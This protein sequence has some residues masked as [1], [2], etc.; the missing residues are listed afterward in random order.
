LRFRKWPPTEVRG[1][2]SPDEQDPVRDSVPEIWL[3][4]E[5]RLLGLRFWVNVRGLPGT[6]DVA[7][8]RARIEVFVDGCFWP[9][10]D[11]HGLIPKNDRQ[12][13][14]DKITKTQDRGE[15]RDYALNDWAGR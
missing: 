9:G 10:C 5:L 4:R 7:F 3:R 12:W 8:S 15:R 13:W 6:P 1:D 14:E 11:K 2:Q